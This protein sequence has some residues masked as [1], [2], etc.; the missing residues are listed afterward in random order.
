MTI[1][2]HSLQMNNIKPQTYMQTHSPPPPT[3]F[4]GRGGWTPSLPLA[5][6]CGILKSLYPKNVACSVVYDYDVNI[7][8]YICKRCC[9][10]P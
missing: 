2:D 4:Q 6:C 3:F 8:G 7:M 9:W 10:R 5:L 1:Y